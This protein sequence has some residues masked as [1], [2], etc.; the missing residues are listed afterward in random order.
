MQYLSRD[1]EDTAMA[2]AFEFFVGAVP[3]IPTA[4]MRAQRRKHI[5]SFVRLLDGPDCLMD[6]A[7]EIAI[8]NCREIVELF[9]LT[10]RHVIHAPDFDPWFLTALE[11]RGYHIPD[12]RHGQAYADQ[13]CRRSCH[14]LK[15][16]T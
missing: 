14:P 7:F 1:I 13:S 11:G 2:G 4:E 8:L 12:E 9:R 16:C 15:E 5:D 3:V 10:N 6:L